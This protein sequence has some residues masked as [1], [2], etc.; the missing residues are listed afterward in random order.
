MNYKES[1]MRTLTSTLK[2]L[3]DD[4]EVTSEELYELILLTVG[5][6]INTHREVMD[7]SKTLRD[8]L[9][10]DN[11]V[12]G[13]RPFT[14]DTISFGSAASNYSNDYINF[15]NDDVDHSHHYYKFDRNK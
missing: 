2:K 10:S 8:K 13:F 7:K 4:P 12:S 1:E 5:E 11:G 15:V 6:N 3:L 9:M 14:S